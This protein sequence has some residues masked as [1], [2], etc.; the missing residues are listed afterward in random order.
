MQNFQYLRV[1]WN[2]RTI[3]LISMASQIGDNYGCTAV[4]TPR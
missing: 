2:M 3:L 4:L 1:K